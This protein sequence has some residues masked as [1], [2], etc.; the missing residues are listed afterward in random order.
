MNPQIIP[1]TDPSR[2]E[3]AGLPWRTV[4]Q[5]RWAFR[6]RHE[7]GLAGCFVRINRNIAINVPKFHELA[8]QRVA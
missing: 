4:D 3:S 8:A 7:N 5:A 1:I 6:T 2:F